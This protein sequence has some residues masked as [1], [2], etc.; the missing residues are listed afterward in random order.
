MMT[1]K[2]GNPIKHLS[3]TWM[4][5]L[6]LTCGAMG[7]AQAPPQDPGVP[8]GGK[9][10]EYTAEDPM[11]AAKKVRFELLANNALDRDSSAKVTIFC[12][13]GKLALSDFRP[14]IKMAGP[15]RPGFWGQPQME[16]TVRVDNSHSEHGWNWVDGH[17]LS[18]DKG[19]TRELIGAHL[20]RVEFQT[21][22][23]PE[24]AEFSPDGLMLD[25]VSKACS[26]TPK[27]P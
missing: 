16:V 17:F 2:S 26:L 27:R 1:N 23:G 25:R 19:T 10:M 4:A 20:F 7:F 6:I 13:D 5:S 12:T 11:T 15:N 21:R 3:A 18:M 24:I 9:W 14:N 22:Q 8:A